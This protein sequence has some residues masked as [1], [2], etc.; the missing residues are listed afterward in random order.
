MSPVTRDLSRDQQAQ[1]NHAS[2]VQCRSSLVVIRVILKPARMPSSTQPVPLTE[3]EIL[4]ALR[5]CYE[6]E[7]ALNIVD[8]GLVESISIAP[9]PDA[10]GSGIPGVPPRHRVHISLILSTP[11][12]DSPLPAQIQN[13]LAAFETISRTEIDVLTHPT[14]TP[15][16]ISPEGR[17]RFAAHLASRKAVHNLVQ[18]K[19]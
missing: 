6:P 18:I 16:R 7:I 13:R 17:Q 10:P 12:E 3:A 14:W 2:T 1:P 9:D 19:T 4:A 11:A 8:L 5:D 15:E